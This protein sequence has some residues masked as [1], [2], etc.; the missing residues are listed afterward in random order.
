MI[1][2][3]DTVRRKVHE[4][5]S[6][7]TVCE[8][9]ISLSRVTGRRYPLA[10][11]LADNCV[12]AKAGLLARG[13]DVRISLPGRNQWIDTE[14]AAYSCEGSRRLGRTRPA[15]PFHPP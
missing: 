11:H 9:E 4:R 5:V 15:F 10:G 6:A 2:S 7:S 13:S 12:C 3:I 14:L 1:T 8:M